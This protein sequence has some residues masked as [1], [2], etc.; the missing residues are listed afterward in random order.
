[1]TNHV[2][3]VDSALYRGEIMICLK[4]RTSTYTYASV[5]ALNS[6]MSS[7]KYGVCDDNKNMKDIV[8][9]AYDDAMLTKK[10]VLDV[11]D[12]LHFAPY[13]VG[14]RIAQMVVLPYPDISLIQTDTLSSTERQDGGFGSTGK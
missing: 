10:A 11:D 13:Q 7:M 8:N 5:N 4:N 6:F 2:G 12:E 9:K 3:I 14:D 1:M